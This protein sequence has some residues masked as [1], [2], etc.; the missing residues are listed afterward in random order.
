MSKAVALV[1]VGLGRLVG[2]S[3]GAARDPQTV[4]RMSF[5]VQ[6]FGEDPKGIIS[7]GP[8]TT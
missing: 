1:E 5:D 8:L 7:P 3:C 4:P 6:T 2:G